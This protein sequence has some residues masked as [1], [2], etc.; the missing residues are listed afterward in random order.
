MNYITRKAI[1]VDIKQMCKC[2]KES[3]PVV[4]SPRDFAIMILNEKYIVLVCEKEKGCELLGYIISR[5]EKI[6]N[7][8][9]G[10]I[11]A[12]AVYEKYRCNGIGTNLMN[13][14]E[15]LLKHYFHIT[16]ITL[17]VKKRNNNAIKFY[18]EKLGYKKYLKKHKYY[19]KNEHGIMMRKDLI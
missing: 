9:K 11:V 3:L 6:D 12:I 19:G 1:C 16:F 7:K 15:R 5:K 18:K 4:Y 8:E 13:E 10:H 14:S 17:N 2:N